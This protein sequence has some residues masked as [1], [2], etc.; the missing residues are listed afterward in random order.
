MALKINHSIYFLTHL[1][2]IKKFCFSIIYQEV[3]KIYLKYEDNKIF[4]LCLA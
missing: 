4:Y 3:F 1:T 2:F